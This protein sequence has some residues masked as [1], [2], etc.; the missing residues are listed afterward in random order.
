MEQAKSV[1]GCRGAMMGVFS[2]GADAKEI[3]GEQYNDSFYGTACAYLLRRFGPSHWGCDDY[4]ELTHSILT[5]EMKGVFLTVRPGCSVSTSFG[6]YLSPD[7]YHETEKAMFDSRMQEPDMRTEIEAC[8][9]R[10]P[11]YKALIDAIE[12]LKKP[13]NV[14]D[15]Y[16]NITGMVKD[17][18]LQYDE[19]DENVGT[20]EYSEYAGYGI[21]R[22][23][24]DKFKKDREKE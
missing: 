13:V 4:K 9:I 6:Y 1:K 11:V 17:S 10:K 3:L 8:P 22:D 24:F 23:Y 18:D 15:W 5:T 7:I 14:R 20:A 16:F 21:T 12:E 19:D 2:P